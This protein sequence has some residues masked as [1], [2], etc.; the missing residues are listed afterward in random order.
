MPASDRVKSTAVARVDWVDYAKGICIVLVVLMHSTLGVQK[1][2]GEI[3]WLNSFIEWARPFRMPDFFMISGLFLASRIERPWREYLDS[4]AAHFLYFYVLWMTILYFAKGGFLA[5]HNP[6]ELL[7]DWAFGFIQ[8]NGALWF[9]YILPVF[10]IVLKLTRQVPPIFMFIIGAVLE[11][12]P[13]HTG[14][15][16][17]DEFA[18]RF[19]YVYA[20]YWMAQRIFTFA[21]NIRQQNTAS[22]LAALAVWGI[23]NALAVNGGY[24]I[25]PGVSLAL[26]LAGACAVVTVGVLLSQ[27]KRAGAI[28]YCGKNS[29]IIYLAFSLF[30]S[31]ARAVLLKI[32]MPSDLG[33]V[34][35]ICTVCGITGPLLLYWMTRDTALKFLFSRP[36]WAHLKPRG[37]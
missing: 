9:I 17:V 25:L 32:G 16:M 3:T 14:W 28:R 22:I 7:K 34:T 13:I 23:V 30:M 6:G 1:A 2:T 11:A 36:H 12:L 31:S 24:A 33:A 21:A 5:A 37:A 4:K 19:V 26:G 20:G 35:L 18:N 29:I 15:D 10:M 8:P 27:S